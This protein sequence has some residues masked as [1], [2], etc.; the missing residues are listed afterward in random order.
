M[1]AVPHRDGQSPIYDDPAD[2][3]EDDPYTYVYSIMSMCSPNKEILEGVGVGATIV[4][5]VQCLR[6]Y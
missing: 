4:I 2:G 6:S 1:I 5:S 3:E